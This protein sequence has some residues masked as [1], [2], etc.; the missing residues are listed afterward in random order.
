M[1]TTARHGEM[2]ATA[3][4][5]LLRDSNAVTFAAAAGPALV[6]VVVL[7]RRR[8]GPRRRGMRTALAVIMVVTAFSLV[9]QLSSNRG[10]T[11]FHNNVGLRWLLDDDMSEWMQDRGMPMSNALEAR[12]GSDAW[13]D[14]EAFLRSPFLEEYREWA[15]GKGRVAAAASFVVRADW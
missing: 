9:G 3:A 10:E 5:M 11:S 4:W 6:L 7:E 12:A 14:G 13:A 1:L 2:A 8:T 15:D